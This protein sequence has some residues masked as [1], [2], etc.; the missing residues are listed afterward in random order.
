LAQHEK[1]V[2]IFLL[3]HIGCNERKNHLTLLSL[4]AYTEIAAILEWFSFY[5]V[6]SKYAKSILAC[7]E[8]KLKENK[9]IWRLRQGYFSVYGEH[10]NRHKRKPSSFQQTLK[11]SDP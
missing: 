1:N 8:K 7:M 2:R 11:N 10:A 5:E 6:V 4:E 9:H 3:F